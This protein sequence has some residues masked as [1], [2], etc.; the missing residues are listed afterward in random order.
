MLAQPDIFRFRLQQ[1]G[2]AG[3]AGESANT[4][5]NAQKLDAPAFGTKAEAS[6]VILLFRNPVLRCTLKPP[7]A[8]TA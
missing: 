6:S 1:Y 5:F 8:P 3:N 2:R 7:R 4:R